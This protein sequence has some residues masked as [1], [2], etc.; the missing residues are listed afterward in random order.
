M[1]KRITRCRLY[2]SCIGN[3][4]ITELT[5]PSGTGI[6]GYNVQPEAVTLAAV[7]G[8]L[9]PATTTYSYDRLGNIQW[10][11][12]PRNVSDVIRYRYDAAG[13]LV[14]TVSGDPDGPSG[15]LPHLA[16]RLTRNADG[17]VTV[18]ETG[19]VADYA[20]ADWNAMTVSQRFATSYDA[21][22]R[23]ESSAQTSWDGNTIYSLTVA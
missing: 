6:F 8:S 13:Q 18:T 2:A 10:L 4:N 19:H 12:G 23:T 22:G 5:Y 3:G 21:F 17:Q 1:V 16:T 7:D 20:D 15:P 11:N 9:A 14:G